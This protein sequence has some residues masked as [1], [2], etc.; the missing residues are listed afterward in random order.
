MKN[1]VLNNRR[2]FELRESALPEPGE[3]EVLVSV[4]CCSICRTDA[5]MWQSG[6]R[7]LVL[8][9]IPGHEISGYAE[10]APHMPVTIWP[11]IACGVCRYCLEGRE[12]LC[13]SMRIL[14]FH[15]DGGFAEF[16]SV[17]RSSL[18]ALPQSMP[19]RLAALA[20]PLACALHG[21]DRAALK[22]GERVLVYGAGTLGLFLALGVHAR[23]ALPIV[24]DPCREKLEKSHTLRKRFGITGVDDPR[25]ASGL[26]DVMLNAASAPATLEGILKLRAG[27]R[28]CMFSN[29]A[30]IPDSMSELLSALHY[31][32]LQLVGAY[33]CTRAT[34]ESSVELLFRY[35]N[36]LAF[37]VER[38]ISL[39][40][41]PA[42]MPEVLGG[43]HFKYVID[44]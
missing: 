18:I 33:G 2:V 22:A 34:M 29:L 31:R 37:L 20:E 4:T 12:N 25:A 40:E 38:A 26:F 43:E 7:D 28:F 36:E 30:A 27:G 32:E 8:P 35:C 10:G 13:A 11:G 24:V 1:L 15:R 5:R 19:M 39:E 41:A 6:H 21:L 9:R 44:L 14:G 23:G 42:I 16:V 3:G 17:P